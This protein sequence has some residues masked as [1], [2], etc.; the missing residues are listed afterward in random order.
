MASAA[1]SKG[2]VDDA[3]GKGGGRADP[4]L[5][6]TTGY[7]NTYERGHPRRSMAVRIGPGEGVATQTGAPR[8][9]RSYGSV[10]SFMEL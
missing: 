3:C 5:R 6:V 8:I 2:L 7:L 10:L 4:S 1:D 9:T